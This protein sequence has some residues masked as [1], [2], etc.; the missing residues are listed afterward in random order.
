M[1]M[2]SSSVG[3]TPSIPVGPSRRWGLAVN[4]NV[5]GSNPR[6]GAKRVNMT[7]CHQSTWPF[8]CATAV[9]NDGRP[10]SRDSVEFA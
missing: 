1:P 6:A 5:L 8:T 7:S 10:W 2:L 4:E 9:E 3:R